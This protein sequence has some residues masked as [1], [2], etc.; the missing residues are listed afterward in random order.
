VQPDE[1]QWKVE[2]AVATIA[3]NRPER[4]NAL[5]IDVMRELA[6]RLDEAVRD[7]SVRV[8]VLTGTGEKAFS[9]GADLG[10]AIQGAGPYAMH[11]GRG[12]FADLL[13]QLV[14]LEKPVIARVNGAALGGG[15]G[16][17]LACD[18][19]IAA[20][21]ATFGTPEID[22]G[23]FPMMIMPLIFRHAN[24]RKLALEMM[25]TGEK[26]SAEVAAK[27]GFVNRVVPAAELDPAVKALAAKIAAK[28]P[29]VLRLGRQAFRRMQEMPF[30][31]SLDYLKCMLTVDTL[32]D[33]AAEGVTAF[34]EKR[35]PRWKGV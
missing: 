26:F 14:A 6:R 7:A 33:D 5:S 28:S 10:S 4:R 11:E 20:D 9:A 17:A 15:F 12:L 3:L 18:L 31:A 30:D 23:L 24:H 32:T 8:V 19:A 27:Q 29:V 25:L 34:M 16:L 13:R 21:T 2:D 22:L 35:A 1:V